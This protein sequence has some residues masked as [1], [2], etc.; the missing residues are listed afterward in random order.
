MTSTDIDQRRRV[1]HA[2]RLAVAPGADAAFGRE[3]LL[4][5]RIVDRARDGLAV[6]LER[7]RGAEDRNAVRVVGGAVERVEHPAVAGA[8]ARLPHLL[9]EHVVIGK[10][11]R[12]QRAEH[13]LHFDVDLGD[14]VDRALLV[15][16]Q[17]R[18]RSA[19]SAA[20]R[21]ARPPRPRSRETVDRELMSR[22]KPRRHGDSEVMKSVT[23]RFESWISVSASRVSV[24]PWLVRF[25][26]RRGVVVAGGA[27]PDH[28]LHH[29]DFHAA[30]GAAPHVHF[31]HEAADQEDAAAAG[32]QDVLRR[33]RIGDLLRVEAL[34]LVFDADDELGRVVRGDGR[35]LDDHAFRFVV[36][37][38]MLDGVDHGFANRD[39]DPV[40][41]IVVQT[42]QSPT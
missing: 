36:P 42:G 10:S 6:D 18:T 33:Q 17:R 25:R 26:S 31:V 23:P 35:E 32:L 13:P 37:V 8:G 9:G 3:Q 30:L 22:T 39:A 34:A 19:P 11:R 5:V 27:V 20:R 21:R 16:A 1:R 7:H 24:S 40:Q 14:E 28:L 12:D 4:A 38:A 29:A 41:R 2:D 15:D